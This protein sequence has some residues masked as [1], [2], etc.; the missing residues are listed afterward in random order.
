M[1]EEAFTSGGVTAYRPGSSAF[2]LTYFDRL[3]N[4]SNEMNYLGA[5]ML[6]PEECISA[7]FAFYEIFS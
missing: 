3:H 5:G 4:P 7:L 1:P 2:I 6:P